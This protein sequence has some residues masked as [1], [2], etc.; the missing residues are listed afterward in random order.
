CSPSGRARPLR[1]A[2]RR[3][4]TPGARRW[5]SHPDREARLREHLRS[6]R[7]A[8]ERPGSRDTSRPTSFG[9]RSP[10]PDVGVLRGLAACEA[11]AATA[12]ERHAPSTGKP[13][14]TG[15]LANCCT[16]AP[17]R[18]AL[19]QARA[20]ETTDKIEAPWGG[21]CVKPTAPRGPRLSEPGGPGELL[22]SA[23][24]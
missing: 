7:A 2:C 10:S 16:G 6:R 14:S 23:G 24:R 22:W 15:A 8:R 20:D 12:D 1:P 4:L 17:V 3:R 5:T 13:R 9:F 18:C 11:T 21:E 19:S